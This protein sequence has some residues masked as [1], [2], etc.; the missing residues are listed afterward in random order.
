MPCNDPIGYHKLCT[1]L[2]SSGASLEASDYRGNTP[3]H[4]AAENGIEQAIVYLKP[5]GAN[6]H[7]KNEYVKVCCECNGC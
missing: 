4:I 2:A 1:L 6:L 7:A 3:L 5:L